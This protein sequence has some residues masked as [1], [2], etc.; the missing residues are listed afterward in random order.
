VSR[1]APADLNDLKL[2]VQI[3]ERS[4]QKAAA[5]T[6][7]LSTDPGDTKSH[8]RLIVELVA[9]VSAVEGEEN[10]PPT[11]YLKTAGPAALYPF[12]REVVAN[13]TMRGRF[14]PVW[15]K[16][17]NFH[18]LTERWR[19]RTKVED[20]GKAKQQKTTKSRSSKSRE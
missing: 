15:L 9:T 1:T 19:G 8:Y 5:L 4:D 13:L 18:A 2:E 6:L 20:E 11:E 17:F 12:L 10:L 7:R 14:G 3:G 16:P